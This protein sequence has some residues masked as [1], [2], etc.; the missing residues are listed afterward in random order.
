VNADTVFPADDHRSAWSQSQIARWDAGGRL[1]R[2]AVPPPPDQTPSQMALRFCLSFPS[3]A[4][5]IPGIMTPAEAEENAAAGVA[6]PLPEDD[7]QRILRIN[8]DESFFV[9]SPPPGAE[10]RP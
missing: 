7:V 2:D 3:V 8:R 4:T 6:G 1:M 5:V 10:G 9:P